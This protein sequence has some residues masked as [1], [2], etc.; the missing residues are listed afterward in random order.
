VDYWQWRGNP[1][2]REVARELTQLL[3]ELPRPNPDAFRVLERL[4]DREDPFCCFPLVNHA[5][6]RKEAYRKAFTTWHEKTLATIGRDALKSIYTVV[7]GCDWEL[8]E[9]IINPLLGGTWW[10]VLGVSPIASAAEV[11]EAH[12]RLAK[13][14]HP[15]VN[16]SP[17]ARERMVTINRAL[18]EFEN[19]GSRIGA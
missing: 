11:K 17:L 9:N 12:R 6:E 5:A 4:A 18:E 8:I 3:E 19:A 14:W 1:E 13:E 2:S 10:Q 15:D 7:Y 16:P